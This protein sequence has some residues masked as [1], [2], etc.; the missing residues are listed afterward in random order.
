MLARILSFFLRFT[1]EV[2]LGKS[3]YFQHREIYLPRGRQPQG[4]FMPAQ[5][6]AAGG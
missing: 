2:F 4:Q 3:P 5:E 1:V 6:K